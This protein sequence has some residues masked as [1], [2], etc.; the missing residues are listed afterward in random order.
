MKRKFK[1]RLKQTD[2]DQIDD[3]SLLL[4]VYITQAITFIIGMV[5]ILFQH[6][7]LL[8]LFPLD[9][10]W[11][12]ACYGG[13]FAFIVIM[14]DLAVSA[15]V[16]EEVTD[17][18][19]VNERLFGSRALWHIIVLTILVSICEELLFRG[20]VQYAFGAYWTS[21]IFA[22]IHFRYLK[23]WL[24]TLFVFGISY[25]LGWIYM[26]TGSLWTPVLAHFI[27]DIVMGVTLRSRSSRKS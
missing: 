6:R 13:A 27:I 15:V 2:L 23:H 9:P 19:G 25:G 22:A 21:I 1:I 26:Q 24:M 14:A 17:D 18:G 4:N 20:A 16:P 10:I 11:R 7:S 12:I 5:V 3:R 8:S